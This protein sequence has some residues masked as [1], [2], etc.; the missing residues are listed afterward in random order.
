MRLASII[1]MAVFVTVVCTVAP[2]AHAQHG[3]LALGDIGSAATSAPARSAPDGATD[4]LSASGAEP[5][6]LA[7]M[8]LRQN[9]TRAK[10]GVPSL[11]WSSDL[12][13]RTREKVQAATKTSCGV[14]ALRRMATAEGMVMHWVSPLRRIDGAVVSQGISASYVVSEWSAGRADFDS[15]TGLC[16]RSGA[17][18]SYARM[19]APEARLVGCAKVTCASGAQVFACSY[20]PGEQPQPAKKTSKPKS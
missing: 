11:V 8:L 3:I 9:E 20:S 12:A 17:C 2:S 10:L 4:G 14:S 19:T 1:P 16:R 13:A 5:R 6:E 18:D 15:A 7:G